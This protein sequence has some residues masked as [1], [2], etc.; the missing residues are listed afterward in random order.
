VFFF[1]PPQLSVAGKKSR[2][3]CSPDKSRVSRLSTLVLVLFAHVCVCFC[4]CLVCLL[5]HIFELCMCTGSPRS[6]HTCNYSIRSSLPRGSL[7]CHASYHLSP[8]LGAVSSI[9]R[10]GFFSL[11]SEKTSARASL[12]GRSFGCHLSFS[13]Q[14]VVATPW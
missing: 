12:V 4:L 10:F 14:V 2:A 7:A 9:F 1:T 8:S 5:M 3:C 13:G 6:W 11:L